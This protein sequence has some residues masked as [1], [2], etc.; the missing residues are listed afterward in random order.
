MN[1]VLNEGH[2]DWENSLHKSYIRSIMMTAAD[3]SGQGKPYEI[4]KRLVENVLK[5]FYDEVRNTVYLYI[6]YIE[7]FLSYLMFALQ[8]F[9]FLHLIN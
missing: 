2:L 3:L 6:L 1:S 8:L 5:E 4:A 7:V 9:L